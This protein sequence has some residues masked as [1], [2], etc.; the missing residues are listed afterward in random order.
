MPKILF[1][2]STCRHSILSVMPLYYIL[3][4]SSLLVPEMAVWQRFIKSIS[5]AFRA[6]LRKKQLFCRLC[7]ARKGARG[8]YDHPGGSPVMGPA[9]RPG[10]KAPI[11]ACD[12][13]LAI[14]YQCALWSLL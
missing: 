11:F 5:S 4:N 12:R 6:L 3:T 7:S 1:T 2:M 9:S 10:E 13:E 8:T 14:F